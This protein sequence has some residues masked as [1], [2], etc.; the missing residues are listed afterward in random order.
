MSPPTA[1]LAAEIRRTVQALGRDHSPFLRPDGGS[2]PSWRRIGLGLLAGGG[3]G[4]VATVQ[5]AILLS[6]ILL[7]AWTVH[8]MLGGLSSGTAQTL[9]DDLMSGQRTPDLA[10]QVGL[11]WVTAAA[12]MALAACLVLVGSRLTRTRSMASLTSAP[13]WRW[14]HLLLGLVLY[15]LFILAMTA[16]EDPAGAPRYTAIFRTPATAL[17]FSLLFIPAVVIAAAAEEFIFRGWILRH[18]GRKVARVSLAVLVALAS[19]MVFSLIHWETDFDPNAIILRAAVGLGLCYV[20][21][22]MGGVEM[23][24]GAHAANNL[25]IFYLFQPFSLAEAAVEPFDPWVILAAAM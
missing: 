9:L 8:L 2:E 12:N 21:L 18:A 15:G 16:F 1:N 23:A 3:V 6:V 17:I 20:T 5:I 25:V 13:G 24:T 19:S 14:R 4:A 11:I 22:R 7:I 10:E